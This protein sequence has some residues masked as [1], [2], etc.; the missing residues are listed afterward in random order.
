MLTSFG[1]PVPDAPPGLVSER[2]VRRLR[3]E[4][5]WYRQQMAGARWLL[6]HHDP[7]HGFGVLK[8]QL[9]WLLGSSRDRGLS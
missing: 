5:A 1:H 4:V 9:G 7:A 2:E 6:D 8:V 3:D